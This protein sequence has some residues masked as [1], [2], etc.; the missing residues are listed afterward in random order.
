MKSRELP[1]ESISSAQPSS[2]FR[3]SFLQLSLSSWRF[4]Q[5]PDLLAWAFVLVYIL[6]FTW[7]AMLRHDSFDSSGFDLGIYDQVVWNTLHGRPFF[8]TTTGQPLLHLSNHASPI[9]L[10][11]APFYLI[12]SGPETLL[13]LQTAAIGLGG[14]PLFWLAREKLGNKNPQIS[15]IKEENKSGRFV[16]VVNFQSGDLAALSLLLAYLLFPTLQIV[17]LWDF[18]PPAL[19]VGFFMAAFYCLVK[20][21]WGWFLGW[22]FLAMLCKEQLPLQVAFLGAAAIV[23][24]RQWRVGLTTIVVALVYFFIIMYWVIPVNS[25]TGDHLFIGFYAE[26]GDTPGEIMLTALTRPDLVLKI[27]WQPTRWEYLVNI[28]T[29]FAYLP[30]IG[31][32]ILLIGAPS[33]AINL[34]SAN[35]AMHDASR[36]QYG[37]DV[38]PWL[39]WAAL[40]G[41]IY[42]RRFTSQLLDV[43]YHAPRTT[44]QSSIFNPQSLISN[45]LPALLLTVALIWQLYYGYSPLALDPPRWE[46]TAHD[47]LAQRFMAQIPAEAS[48]AAQG[49]LYPHLSNRLIAYQLPDVN[50]AEYVFFDATT[51]TWPVHPNDMWALAEKLL[52]SGQFGVLDAADGYLLLQRGLART[53][54]PDDFY[55][56]ARVAAPNPQYPLTVEFGDQVRLVGFEVSDDPRRQETSVRLY[57]QALKPLERPLRLYPFFIDPEGQV[58][59]NTEQRPL[60]TQLWYP[61]KLWKPGEIVMAETLPW[62]LSERWSLAMGVLAGQDWLDWSQ[63]LPVQVIDSARPL[64]RFEANTWVRLATFER[65]GRHLVEV[66]PTESMVQ[67]TYPIQA[68]FEGKMA[69]QGYDV[70]QTGSVLAVTLY[71]QALAPMSLDYTVF[72]HLLDPQGQTVAQHDG[73]PAW[74]VSVPTSTWQLGETVPDKHTLSLPGNLSPGQ[75]RLQVGV[76]YWQT[77]ERLV[78]VENGTVVNNFVE[79]GKVTLER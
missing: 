77:L 9:L 16:S 27:L 54:I 75:Y 52:Y 57:W 15:Q 59:E 64:R 67:P 53:S 36:A 74:E 79:L 38:A 13:F 22:S 4:S 40:Y 34:L 47:R 44:H 46:I 24:Q 28:L 25:V 37:A 63:R 55:S 76:Y 3:P 17:N 70:A 20:Q 49:K 41:L 14:L 50:E 39:A 42:L 68:D 30:L 5:F 10:L 48:V 71:W 66:A 45:L 31:L 61:P 65:R 51:A 43:R 11:V 60:L 1:K 8:Y 69:L 62:A 12:H 18:H 2:G 19:A 23:M 6:T 35:T 56:F 29:P 7:L 26:L 21:K 78:V 73:Q 32:P 72:V 58:V 33:F